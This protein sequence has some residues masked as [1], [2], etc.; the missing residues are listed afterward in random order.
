[1]TTAYNDRELR[2]E[3]ANIVL[4]DVRSGRVGRSRSELRLHASQL[5]VMSDAQ[6]RELVSF[7]LRRLPPPNPSRE[8]K[9]LPE[10]KNVLKGADVVPVA[11]AVLSEHPEM[12]SAEVYEEILRRGYRLSMSAGSF[13]GGGYFRNAKAAVESGA[14]GAAPP[15]PP[16]PEP[17]PEPEES[18]VVSDGTTEPEAARDVPPEPASSGDPRPEPAWVPAQLE[19][20]APEVG[21]FSAGDRILVHIG[22]QKLD[23]RR[24]DERWSVEFEGSVG[25]DVV[26]A[27]LGRVLGGS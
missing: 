5:F 4:D 19:S 22:A 7:V 23:A 10:P 14:A 2:E 3:R 13:V 24:S 26:Q 20:D 11:A 6:E 25:D 17:S 8:E 27:L 15:P 21:A 1:M 16:R 12:R 18:R 9:P